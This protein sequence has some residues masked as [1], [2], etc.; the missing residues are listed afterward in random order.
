MN[1]LDTRITIR[2]CF[3]EDGAIYGYD[4]PVS[5]KIDFN[6]PVTH[7]I[8]SVIDSEISSLRKTKNVKS[9][10]FTMMVWEKSGKWLSINA[11]EF[12]ELHGVS[13]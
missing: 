12:E 4:Y 3:S 9:A 5:A 6:Q 7:Q 1:V 2:I 13:E 11:R 8:T 10:D